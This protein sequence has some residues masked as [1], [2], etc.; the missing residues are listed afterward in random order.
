MSNYHKQGGVALYYKSD[1]PI[2]ERK[3]LNTLDECIVS[4][5]KLK[6]E[7]IF[8]VLLYRSPSHKSSSEVQIF[9][10]ALEKLMNNLNNE[11]PSC[12]I[13]S[14]D[15]NYRSSLIWSRET[16]EEIPGRMIANFANTNNLDQLINEATHLPRENIAT[17]V[18]LI[19]TNQPFLF[20]DSGVISSPDEK[21]KHQVIHGKVN[22]EV[23][24]PPKYTRKM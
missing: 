22:F 5:I 1:L 7:K 6:N 10:N 21:C 18:D 11:K 2:R 19:F 14:G 3:D 20:V 24:V 23:P 15:F 13:L 12:I 17:C 9:V 8:F 4:E 16:I